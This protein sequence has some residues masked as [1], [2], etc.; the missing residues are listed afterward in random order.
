MCMKDQDGISEHRA[1]GP[2]VVR[3]VSR[4]LQRAASS[5]RDVACRR[6][7]RLEGKQDELLHH[8]P[9]HVN[10]GPVF[11]WMACRRFETCFQG[12]CLCL[13][14]AACLARA[15]MTKGRSLLSS[16]QGGN[17]GRAALRDNEVVSVP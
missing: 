8:S 2:K 3:G 12:L 9:A 14:A 17:K 6:E 7:Q 1:D 13:S 4:E 16:V 5:A 10:Q 11:R 15:L